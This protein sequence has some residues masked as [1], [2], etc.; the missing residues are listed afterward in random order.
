M[1]KEV[2]L[3]KA[4]LTKCISSD[5]NE[6]VNGAD[7]LYHCAGELH[8]TNKMEDLHVNGTKKLIESARSSK[9]DRWVQLSSVGVYGPFPGVLVDEAYPCQP[10]GIYEITKSK[11]D[12]LVLEEARKKR[13][14]CFF[15]RP[16]IIFSPK[17]FNNSLFQLIEMI[18]KGLFF[19]IGKHGAYSNYIH[20][21]NVVHALVL[22]GQCKP[23]KNINVYNLSDIKTIEEFVKIISDKLD[24]SQPKFRLPK[25]PLLVIS[26]V[27][28]SMIRFPLT[29]NRIKSLSD[30]T[31]YDSNKI[32][33]EL[34]YNHKI[35][36]NEGLLQ[37]V[38]E[39]LKRSIGENNYNE[40]ENFKK[41]SFN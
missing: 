23:K 34:G 5:L 33:K 37:M 8:D 2:E 7:V 25:W 38:D 40:I 4:D 13:F 36:L 12:N 17:M 11:S 27:M 24:R 39:Y 26:R 1:I 14:N 28:N 22:C 9:V 16:S 19:F 35:S 29:V 32:E 3:F 20:I 6:F 18:D 10:K 21:D 41:K 15:L 31:A 30:R